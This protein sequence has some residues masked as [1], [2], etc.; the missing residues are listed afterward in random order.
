MSNAS[1]SA[2]RRYEIAS[3]EAMSKASMKTPQRQEWFIWGAIHRVC[4]TCSAAV[5]APCMNLLERRRGVEKQV[6]W[7]HDARVDWPKVWEGLKKRG[8]IVE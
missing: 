4:P 1:T 6:R 8:Y 5:G 2:E 3:K 7:P